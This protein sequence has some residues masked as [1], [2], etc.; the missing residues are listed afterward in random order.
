MRETNLEETIR[1]I[2]S[3]ILQLSPK[4]ISPELSPDTCEK[5]DSLNHIHLVNAINETLEIDLSVEQQVEM[6]NFDLVLEVVTEA[7]R[8][9]RE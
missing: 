8:G 5:W 7:L 2:F 3:T 9:K 4:E 1:H 6:L